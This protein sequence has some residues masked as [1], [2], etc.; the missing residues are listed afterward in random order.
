MREE[1]FFQ[2]PDLRKSKFHCD[3]CKMW[4]DLLR[5]DKLCISNF[6]LYKRRVVCEDHFLPN[7]FEG[8]L[9]RP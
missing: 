2:I 6:V 9:R 7:C 4:L 5:N 8:V 3:L 1:F